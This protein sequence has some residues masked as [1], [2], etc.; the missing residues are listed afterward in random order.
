MAGSRFYAQSKVA[1]QQNQRQSQNLAAGNSVDNIG[2]RADALAAA[3]SML[4]SDMLQPAQVGFYTNHI[5]L[6]HLFEL[7]LCTIC[8][9]SGDGAGCAP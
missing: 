2:A 1:A 7:L 8:V 4:S 5:P 6:H 9:L 3:A